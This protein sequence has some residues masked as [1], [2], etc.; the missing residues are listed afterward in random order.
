MTRVPLAHWTV[1]VWT[2]E[3]H[4]VVGPD[5]DVVEAVLCA[6]IDAPLVD[7]QPAFVARAL[8]QMERV[9]AY[10]VVDLNGNGA[11]VYR[12]WP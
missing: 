9:A 7:D 5:S 1:R 8:D 12:D 10:E 6:A 11:V 2:T 4:I 3:D